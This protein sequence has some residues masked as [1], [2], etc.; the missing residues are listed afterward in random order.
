MLFITGAANT[1]KSSLVKLLKE[2]L[3]SDKFDI[4]DI[5]EADRWTDDYES[6]RDAKIEHWLMQSIKNKKYGIE[7]ILCGI[8]YPDHVVKAPSYAEAKPVEYI[9]L[10]ATPEAIKGRYYKKMEPWLS[11]QIEISQEIKTELQGIEDK[12]IVDTT[13]AT[14]DGIAESLIRKLDPSSL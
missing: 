5:D 3:P 1:G 6:W 7:T 8:I 4:H 14:S 13:S 12:Q 9:L 2:G 11:R 10:D